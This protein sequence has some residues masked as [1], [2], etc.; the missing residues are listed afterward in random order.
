MTRTR[1]LDVAA[2][3][4]RDRARRLDAAHRRRLRATAGGAPGPAAAARRARAPRRDPRAARRAARVGSRPARACRSSSRL[5]RSTPDRALARDW[6][7]SPPPPSD[8]SA[9][10]SEDLA[11][12]MRRLGYGLEQTVRR[13]AAAVEATSCA[14]PSPAAGSQLQP[15]S[16]MR[17]V[18]QL[19][20]GG[21]RAARAD[22]PSTTSAPPLD[23]LRFAEMVAG[24]LARSRLRGRAARREPTRWRRSRVPALAGDRTIATSS[25]ARRGPRHHG[26]RASRSSTGTR[27]VRRLA[28]GRPLVRAP[29]LARRTRQS[30]DIE[31]VLHLSS[32]PSDTTP[33]WLMH[34]MET[35]PPWRLSVHVAATDRTRARRAQRLRHKRLWA[36]LRRKERDGKL[37][38]QEAYEQE[39]EAAELDAELRLSGATGIYELSPLPRDPATG[40]RRGRARRAARRRS[41]GT[42]RGC[43]DARLNT[44]RFLVGAVVRLDAS[45]SAVDALASDAT[46][47]AAQRRRLRPAALGIRIQPRRRAA[48]LRRAR[49]DARA[50][51]LL[52]PALPDPRLPDHRRLGLRQDRQRQRAAGAQPRARRARLPDRP[53]LKRG[54][55][56]LDA[57]RRPLRAARRADPGRAHRPPRR[58]PSR[59]RAVSLGHADPS[60]VPAS[61]VEFL[62][63]FHTLLIG[64]H[65]GRRPALARRASSGLCSPAASRPST[66]AAH[67]TG[68]RP[69]EQLLHD[70]L[71]RLAREQAT[72]AADGDASVASELRRLAARL[73]PYIAG[74]S[75][76]WL[77]DEPTTIATDTPLVL[78]DLAGL[79]DALAGPVML[80]L[81]DYIDR[82]VQRHR[83]RHLADPARCRRSV[84]GPRVRRHRRGLEDAD[85]RGRRPVAQRVGAPHPAHRDRAAGHHPAPRRLRQPAGRG[86]A[87]QQRPASDLPDVARRARRRQGRARACTP[88]TSRRSRGSR[89]ARA[90]TRPACSTPRRTAAAVVQLHLGDMEYWT[91]SADP[92]RDQPLR[93]LALD[94]AG[95]D[96]WEALRRLVDPGVAPRPRGGRTPDGGHRAASQA[97]IAPRPSR[98]RC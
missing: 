50:R 94:E 98:R 61:K 95:G 59:R 30:G 35:P 41:P 38:P 76:A 77:A 54:R 62:V 45:R 91:C 81:V 40:R 96:A 31:Q 17:C 87:S 79:P 90:S 42:S 44:G 11:E 74:G 10:A 86:A 26:R 78:F 51:R 14:G 55:R 52:R 85:D 2:A 60:S 75:A 48:R 66:S 73:E 69:R 29:R 67:E 12:A 49:P 25:T 13:S 15:T 3:A 6:R 8:A 58:R 56:R 83:A 37:I 80:T 70:E 33:W 88:R 28:A 19:G 93:Q 71:L 72:D 7:R 9:R 34:L 5:S 57:A 64:D 65:A 1:T 92:H 36:E 39:R 24:E 43:T 23:S 89:P 21:R 22:S 20:L 53:V 47:R 18:R 97:H 63:A 32:A 4:R 68:E 82:D 27:S 16:S 46:V 84:G